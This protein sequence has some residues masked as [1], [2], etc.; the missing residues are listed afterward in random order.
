MHTVTASLWILSPLPSFLMADV[1]ELNRLLQR[2][3]FLP[4]IF[5]D[6]S[7]RFDAFQWIEEEFDN[8]FVDYINYLC[9]WKIFYY[10]LWNK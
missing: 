3:S 9:V 7:S 5:G 6:V 1:S 10:L 4:L 8:L 2:F